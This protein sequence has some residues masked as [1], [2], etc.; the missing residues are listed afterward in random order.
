MKQQAE[1]K[2]LELA[3]FGGGV[4][5]DRAESKVEDIKKLGLWVENE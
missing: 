1:P 3:T 2:S 4:Y 5:P